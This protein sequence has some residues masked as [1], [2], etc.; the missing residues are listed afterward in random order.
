MRPGETFSRTAFNLS[1]RCSGAGEVAVLPAQEFA[2]SSLQFAS[3]SREGGRLAPATGLFES[4]LIFNANE[5][6]SWRSNALFA[7]EW[8]AEVKVGGVDTKSF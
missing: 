6:R 4:R 1:L 7:T 8:H 3:A 2:R 5:E